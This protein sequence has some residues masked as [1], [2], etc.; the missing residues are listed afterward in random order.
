MKA[1]N[2]GVDSPTTIEQI[3]GK[4][5]RGNQQENIKLSR[6]LLASLQLKTL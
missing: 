2:M 5:F 4:L 1:V 3:D 6:T